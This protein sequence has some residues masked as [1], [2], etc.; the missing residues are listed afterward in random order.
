MHIAGLARVDVLS[1]PSDTIYLTV[2][3]ANKLVTHMGRTDRAEELFG[4]HLG[5]KLAPPTGEESSARMGKWVA[6]NMSVE[7]A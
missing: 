2:W 6:R 1:G 7:G 3:A 5:G 4:Q